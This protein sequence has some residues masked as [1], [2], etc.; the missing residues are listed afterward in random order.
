LI[1]LEVNGP[2]PRLQQATITIAVRAQATKI[3]RLEKAMS[4]PPSLQRF[5]VYTELRGTDIWRQS[6][7]V[8]QRSLKSAF[9]GHCKRSVPACAAAPATL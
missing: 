1:V 7:R 5:P 2:A 3:E 6:I 9:P 8:Y 4:E